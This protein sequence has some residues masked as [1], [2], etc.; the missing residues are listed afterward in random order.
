MATATPWGL[1]DYKKKYATGIIFYGTPGHG[2]IHISKKLNEQIHSAW[3]RVNGWYEEDCDWAIVAMTFDQFFNGKEL[4]DA[5][6]TAKNWNPK[7]YMAFTGKEIKPEESY[8]LRKSLFEELHKND[9]VAISAWGDS[10]EGVPKGYVGVFA[11]K[12]GRLPSGDYP[13]GCK[14]FLVLD[15]E[16]SQRQEFGFVIDLWRHSYWEDNPGIRTKRVA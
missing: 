14:Y 11:G 3:R 10:S 6:R 7:G 2:G 4:E 13:D 1:S 12:G 5:E 15:E 16:Y 8:M 9:Y